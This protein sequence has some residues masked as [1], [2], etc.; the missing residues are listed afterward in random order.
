[1]LFENC[2]ETLN[3][4]LDPIVDQLQFFSPQEQQWKIYFNEECLQFN[5]S[6]RLYL[7][8]KIQNP[9]FLPDIFIRTCVINF[10][11]THKGLEDQ[12]L[13]EVMKIERPEDEKIKNENIEKISSY[14]KKM[15]EL[16]KK[17]LLLLVQCDKSPVEDENLVQTL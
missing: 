17:I 7:T 4:S 3:G 12:L 15:K 11:V 13:E 10:T 1:M 8:T 5:P 16:E 9:D 2:K 14:Q 6:F